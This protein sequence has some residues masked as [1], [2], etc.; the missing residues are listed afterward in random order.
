MTDLA[1]MPAQELTQL[2]RS[3]AASPVEATQAVI[4]NIDTY[5]PVLNAFCWL[6]AEAA[7]KA[8][9]ESEARY[10]KGAPLS[11]L[12]GVTATVKDLSVTRGW[13]T[14]RGSLAISAGLPWTED[15]PSVARMREAGAV[16]LGKTTVPE[17]GSRGN[18][19]S[20]LCG[21]TRNPHD[22]THTPGGSSGGAAASLAA[23]MGTIAL[24]SDAAG[25]G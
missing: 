8:A 17:F 19:K 20:E 23:G 5:N 22:P 6:A 7:M 4:N 9:K 10:H 14:R 12:D 16:L 25:S 3:G 2:F 13:P 18:T 15:S 11:P 21:I 24:G 1:M